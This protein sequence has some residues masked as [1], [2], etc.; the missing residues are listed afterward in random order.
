MNNS[1]SAFKVFEKSLKSLQSELQN[2][3]QA[4]SYFPTEKISD[5]LH[6]NLTSEGSSENEIYDHRW[7]QREFAISPNLYE[8]F[9]AF[10]SGQN[11]TEL[12]MER[13]CKAGIVRRRLV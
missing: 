5:I 7:L 2:N 12:M 13:M 11:T 9:Q 3:R 4:R 6:T 8:K 10:W 1:I